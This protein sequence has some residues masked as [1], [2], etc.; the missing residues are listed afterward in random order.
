MYQPG[1]KSTVT[2]KLIGSSKV[3]ANSAVGGGGFQGGMQGSSLQGRSMLAPPR[4]VEGHDLGKT[5]KSNFE[6]TV[7]N[8]KSKPQQKVLEDEYINVRLANSGPAG[9]DQVPGVRAEAAEGQVDPGAGGRERAGQLPEGRDPHQREHPGHEE[10]VQRHQGQIVVPAQL[11][12][13]EEGRGAG[14]A[15]LAEKLDREIA[16]DHRCPPQAEE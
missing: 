16:P 12:Q 3:L 1:S 7:Q 4:K 15:G 6:Q 2:S 5:T 14:G 13:P 8:L 10:Q 9:G 11:A